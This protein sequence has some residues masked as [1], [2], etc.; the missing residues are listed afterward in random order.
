MLT[1]VNKQ[2][3]VRVCFEELQRLVG[4]SGFEHPVSRIREHVGRPHA[5]QHVVVDD[6]NEGLGEVNGITK[7][8]STYLDRSILNCPGMGPKGGGRLKV[9]HFIQT[10]RQ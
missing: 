1:S 10:S 7:A 3:D 6:E 5:F 8:T 9:V 4:T 2:P